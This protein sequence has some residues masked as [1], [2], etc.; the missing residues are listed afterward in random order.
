M[1]DWMKSLVGYML[2]VSVVTQMLPNKKYE[3][4]VKI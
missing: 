1:N 3:Q 4:Y 2:I